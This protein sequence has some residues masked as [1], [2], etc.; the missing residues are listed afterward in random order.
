VNL[1]AAL[2]NS[3]W[4]LF[5][6]IAR[7]LLGLLVGAWVARY[8]GPVAYGEVAY[9][10]AYLAFFQ[11]AVTLGLDG[12][13]VRDLAKPRS[14]AG[15]LLGSVLLMRFGV[16]FMAWIVAVSIMIFTKGWHDQSVVLVAIAGG[17]LVFQTTDT[18]DLWFQS[19][20][21]SRRTVIAKLGSY[22]FS[23]GIR[24]VLVFAHASL[25][26]FV[27]VVLV[28]A[29]VSSVGLVLVYRKTVRNVYWVWN[30][31]VAK[32]L[33]KESWPYMVSGLFVIIYMR[34]D[35]I[36]IREMLGSKDL[37]LYAVILPISS[38]WNV[39]PIVICSSLAPYISRIKFENEKKYYY[40]LL[41]VF[42]F[43]LILG[44]L[45]SIVIAFLSE[46]IV[47]VL[48]GSAYAGAGSVLAI[49]IFT[50]VPVFMGVAQGLWFTN[51]N[52]TSVLMRNTMV[53]GVVAIM[54]NYF[55]LPSMGVK[56][57]AVSAVLSFFASGIFL[58]LFGAK[59][60]FKMQ[61]GIN[62]R[63]SND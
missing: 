10:L 44:I 37:G 29:I 48:Y 63:K 1:H 46:P 17:A 33:I 49:H 2:Y 13:V 62:T 11:V 51:E 7:L 24:V 56:G 23:N 9:V 6:K 4:L 60:V 53:G 54:A 31:E 45:L 41:H 3:G 57:A 52:R 21:Q 5:D 40:S 58:N 16:G 47:G 42:R 12:I 18:I 38:A 26:W 36:M 20:S 14:S 55:L 43:F 15:T 32:K 34:I 27:C 25:T 19:Q 22:F 28:D 50:N 8:L 39:I 61:L 30:Y 35:Q 59:E